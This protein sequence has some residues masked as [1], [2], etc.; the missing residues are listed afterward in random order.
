MEPLYCPSCHR[1]L[2]NRRL[3]NCGF[4]QAEI[5]DELR[6]SDEEIRR[7]DAIAEQLKEEREKREAEKEEERKAFQNRQGSTS[8]DLFSLGL[9]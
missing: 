1:I 7:L 3:K 4:C 2:Y 9:D 6:F 5:P 8:M